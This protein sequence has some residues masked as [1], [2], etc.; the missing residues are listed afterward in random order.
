MKKTLEP[1][2]APVTVTGTV[3]PRSN[4][5]ASAIVNAG[6]AETAW[7]PSSTW[8]AP[9]SPSDIQAGKSPQG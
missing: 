8:A 2:V 6:A 7:R 9:G 1:G 5:G 3:P 4:T